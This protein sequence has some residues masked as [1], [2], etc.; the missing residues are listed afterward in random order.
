[1]ETLALCKTYLAFWTL[2]TL[3]EMGIG[4]DRLGKL[5][6]WLLNIVC[7]H[8]PSDISLHSFL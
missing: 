2:Y 7:F 3:V 8:Y 5:D 6:I 4:L 1:M